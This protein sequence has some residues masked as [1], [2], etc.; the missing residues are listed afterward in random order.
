MGD[1]PYKEIV[2]N[3][4][5]RGIAPSLSDITTMVLIPQ[6]NGNAK[7]QV[8]KMRYD[9]QLFSKAVLLTLL[10]PLDS[11]TIFSPE[12]STWAHHL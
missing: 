1:N 8:L 4:K 10:S 7:I 5:V 12:F 11:G 6:Y 9:I 2:E 3:F